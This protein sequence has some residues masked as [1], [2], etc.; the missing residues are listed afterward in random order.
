[1][2]PK[3]PKKPAKKSSKM[4]VLVSSTVYGQEELLDQVFATLRSLGY[5]VWM[6]HKGTLPVNPKV[7]AFQSC[8]EAV[9][10][11]DL[12]FAVISTNYGSGK[13]GGGEPSIC[14]QELMKAI[15]LDKPRLVLAH[16][17]IINARRLL[18]DLGLNRAGLRFV[19]RSGVIDDLR[20]IDMYEIATREDLPLD[21]RKGNWVQKYHLRED[22]VRYVQEQFGRPDDLKALIEASREV[23]N[24]G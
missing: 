20:L 13:P 1:M 4:K 8:L 12:F 7:S 24:D 23:A 21:Q 3:P 2:T 16:E 9:D 6:S 10:K 11:C 5:E 15:E 14:H 18:L 17:N 19:K 22:V